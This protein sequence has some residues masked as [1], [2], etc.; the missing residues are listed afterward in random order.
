MTKPTIVFFG[1]DDVPKITAK[2]FLRALIYSTAVRGQVVEGMYAKLNHRGSTQIFGFWGYGQTKQLVPGSGLYVGQTGIAVNHHFVLS[3]N[4]PSYEFTGGEYEVEIFARLVGKQQPI[5][6][7]VASVSLVEEH[8]GVLARRGGILFE[9]NP[10][11]Q[12]YVSH[13]QD[14]NSR[15]GN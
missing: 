1:F 4:Q 15:S 13:A 11:G 2:I 10:D 7:S 3:T 12:Q 14:R 8:V 5:R 9:I 6:L